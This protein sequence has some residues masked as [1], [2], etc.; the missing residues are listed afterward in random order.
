[1]T[2]KQEADTTMRA[3]TYAT[4]AIGLAACAGDAAAQSRGRGMSGPQEAQTPSGYVRPV[5][6][7]EK[8][9]PLGAAWIAVSVNGK[10]IGGTERPSFTLDDQ[11]RVRGF[12]GCN[13]FSA[14]AFP[15]K[16]QGIAVGPLAMTKRSCDK[17]LMAAET[18]FL[19]ALR[20]AQKW[21]TV[22]GSLV[23]KGPAG[24]LKFERSL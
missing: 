5:P 1:M 23:L 24:E 3:I 14:T 21:D 10:P 18:S 9:F 16:D 22:I 20:T 8:R 15:L 6:K 13:S 11:F 7:E 17:G 4:L 19:G 2:G 12:A